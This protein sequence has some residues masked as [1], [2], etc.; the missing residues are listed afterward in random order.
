M[1]NRF[2]QTTLCFIGKIEHRSF[3]VPVGSLTERLGQTLVGRKL[4]KGEYFLK[5]ILAEHV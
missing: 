4:A 1:N 2:D 3:L 5:R